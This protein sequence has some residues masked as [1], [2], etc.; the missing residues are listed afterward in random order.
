MR[1]LTKI[2][3]C[4]WQMGYVSAKPMRAQDG[5]YWEGSINL[6][7]YDNEFE[8]YFLSASKEEYDRKAQQ[9]ISICSAPEYL[10]LVDKAFSHEENYCNTLLQPE[11]RPKLMSRVEHELITSRCK[12]IVDQKTGC[13]HMIKEQRLEE[14]KLMY[15]CF[16]R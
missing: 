11:S 3:K 8:H 14:L 2:V 5:F 16:V 4:Y 10:D 6:S 9:W 12:Q 1:L 7:F 15:K 13:M